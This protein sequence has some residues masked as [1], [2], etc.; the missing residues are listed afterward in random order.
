MSITDA[1]PTDAEV[2]GRSAPTQTVAPETEYL[3][4]MIRKINRALYRLAMSDRELRTDLGQVAVRLREL[5]SQIAA[6]S[7]LH[8]LLH[9][10]QV[11][12]EPFHAGLW[13]ASVA[14]SPDERQALLQGWRP[15]QER[16]D[17]LA[18]FAEQA[19]PLGSPFQQDHFELRGEPWAVEPI[20]YRL[21]V[22]DALK[23]DHPD[24]QCLQETLD[25]F[26]SVVRRH[27]EAADRGLQSS[28]AQLQR[29]LASL[30]EGMAAPSARGL[31]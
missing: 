17:A 6:W 12:L 24:P 3:E 29:L 16:L 21:L 11:S 5:A 13:P 31:G 26:E 4:R 7:I 1:N 20:A 10:V 25:E 27:L 30:V 9:A 2:W 28:T 23:E 19:G 14:F 8:R 15:C 18:D 22:E